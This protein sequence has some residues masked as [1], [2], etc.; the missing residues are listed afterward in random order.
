MGTIGQVSKDS[1]FEIAKQ[2]FELLRYLGDVVSVLTIGDFERW[3]IESPA[4]DFQEV[5]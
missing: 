2:A 4:N 5:V 1:A 3:V